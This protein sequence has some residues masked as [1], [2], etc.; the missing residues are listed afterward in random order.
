MSAFSINVVTASAFVGLMVR[1][2]VILVND[3]L[4]PWL[5]RHA[6]NRAPEKRREIRLQEWMAEFD[7]LMARGLILAP[8]MFALGVVIGAVRIRNEAPRWT[9]QPAAAGTR[10]SLSTTRHITVRTMAAC[11]LALISLI[12][13][14]CAA[15]TNLASD[16]CTG[17]VS[18][19]ADLR[20]ATVPIGP[21]LRT[22]AANFTSLLQDGGVEAA[23]LLSSL[24]GDVAALLGS[25]LAFFTPGWQEKQ[26]LQRR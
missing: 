8:L 11:G 19:T 12:S 15:M 9:A 18:M 2:V 24:V 5:I 17:T 25:G 14:C 3:K 10:R 26:N 4:G 23:R 1:D 20:A 22:L 16:I 21:A 13:A 6:A 7:C